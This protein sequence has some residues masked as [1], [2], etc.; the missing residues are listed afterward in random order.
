MAGNRTSGSTADLEIVNQHFAEFL[1]YV[2]TA[3]LRNET[4]K[5]DTRLSKSIS[6]RSVAALQLQSL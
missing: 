1:D 4:L 5:H 6:K 3:E 2:E